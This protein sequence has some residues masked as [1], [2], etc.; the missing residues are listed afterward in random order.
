[1]VTGE[2]L[3]GFRAL[4]GMPAEYLDRLAAIAEPVS[5][6]AGHRLF[7]EG[8]PADACW[9]LAEGRIAL[10]TTVPGGRGAVVL[11]TLGAGDLLGWSWLRPPYRWQFGA[12][13]QAPTTG[14]KLDATRLRALADADPH[15]GYLLVLRMCGVLIDRLQATRARLLDLYRSPG[16]SAAAPLS[17]ERP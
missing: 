2:H 10:E 5:Y 7:R 13:A 17:G 4:A 9:L 6:P 16:G 3:G 1:M 12:R 14:L 15:L 8:Q 11:Q